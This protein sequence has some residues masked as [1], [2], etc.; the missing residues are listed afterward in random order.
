MV[1]CTIEET[2]EKIVANAGEPHLKICLHMLQNEF[3][4]DAEFIKSDQF[5]SYCETVFEKSFRVIMSKSLNNYNRIFMEAR[6][7]EKSLAKAIDEGC[8]G[9]KVDPQI[10]SFE[11]SLNHDEMRGIC[12]EM[13]D[14][15]H[16]NPIE[17]KSR[18]IIPT[19]KRAIN[20]DLLIAKPKLMELVYL[21]EFQAPQYTLDM[22]YMI[23][24]N[25]HGKVLKVE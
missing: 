19:T 16:V 10:A 13:C 12:F 6:P 1:A 17:R 7:I 20:A 23:F 5:V 9:Q 4:D 15:L 2:G 22:V 14:V 8:I 18:Q 24:D 21:V 25:K 3:V 11:G